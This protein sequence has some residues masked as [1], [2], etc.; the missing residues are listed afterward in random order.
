MIAI[1]AIILT[2]NGGKVIFQ[3]ADN[4]DKREQ[5]LPINRDNINTCIDQLI[6][7]ARKQEKVTLQVERGFITGVTP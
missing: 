4:P 5:M 7:A 1:P 2:V 3:F 6:Q